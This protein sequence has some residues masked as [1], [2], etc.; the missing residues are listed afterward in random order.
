LACG[1]V[2]FFRLD[3]FRAFRAEPAVGVLVIIP[4]FGN[5]QQHKRQGEQHED[6]GA[7]QENELAQVGEEIKKHG[8]G[9]YD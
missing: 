1:K 3:V 2:G 6:G 9:I 8:K 5:M 7:G 4:V